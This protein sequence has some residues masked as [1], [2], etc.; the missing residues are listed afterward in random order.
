MF[1]RIFTDMIDKDVVHRVDHVLKYMQSDK[2][3]YCYK[4]E[5][6]NYLWGREGCY[7]NDGLI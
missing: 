3:I 2:Y 6:E 7:L 1:S 5:P 4:G